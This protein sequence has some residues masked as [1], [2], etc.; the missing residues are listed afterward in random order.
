MFS[1][2]FFCFKNSGWFAPYGTITKIRLVEGPRSYAF[3]EYT[4]HEEAAAALRALHQTSIDGNTIS[5]D[6]S[7]AS[8][9]TK[10][11]RN[12]TIILI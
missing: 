9:G 11:R 3:V 2:I 4:E 5:V 7:K 1:F 6:Y 8:S 10:G 12:G